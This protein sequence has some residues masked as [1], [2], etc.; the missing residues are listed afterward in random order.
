MRL[1]GLRI[2]TTPEK[3]AKVFFDHV[4]RPAAGDGAQ[5][6]HP[7]LK[8]DWPVPGDEA[9][10]LIK[11][12]ADTDWAAVKQRVAAD[13]STEGGTV[14]QIIIT[15]GAETFELQTAKIGNHPELKQI[16]SIV[17]QVS[18]VP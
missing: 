16:V 5:I 14:F 11:L 8:K 6:E 17:K 7:V 18:G 3:R 10:T 1:A 13:E 12:V 2:L 15:R 9:A 4:V